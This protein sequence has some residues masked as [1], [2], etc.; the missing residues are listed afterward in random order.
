[1]DLKKFSEFISLYIFDRPK[2]NAMNKKLLSVLLVALVIIAGCNK[3]K[4]YK[5]NLE[6]I[7]Q[8]YKYLLNNVDKSTQFQNE[9]PNYTITFTKDG[10]FT[11]FLTNPDSTYVT[12]TYSFTDNDEKILLENVYNTFVLDTAGDTV[13]IPHTLKREY[14]IFNLTKDHVQLRN[15]TS[16]LYLNKKPE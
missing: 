11:E 5:E 6:G 3:E 16:Q 14:T 9:H 2:N 13:F 8:V 1:M 4:I 12:G 7:W 15:D 10:K